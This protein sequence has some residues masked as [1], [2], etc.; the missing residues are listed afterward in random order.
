MKICVIY[1]NQRK[2]STYNCVQLFKTALQKHTQTEFIEFVLPKDMPHICLGCF[3]C[4]IKGED[5]C[6]HAASVQPIA[7]ALLE[8]DGIIISSPTYACDAASSVKALFDHLCY[9]WVPHRP[10]KEMFNKVVM[11]ISVTAGAGVHTSV[12]TLKKSPRYWCV[13][14]VYGFGM[15]VT[16]AFW[17]DVSEKKKKKL[18]AGLEKKAIQFSSS[19]KK[20]SKPGARLQTRI[21]VPLIRNMVKKYKPEDVLFRDKQYWQANG[22]LDGKKP[23]NI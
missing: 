8:S 4:L 12:K 2:E 19:L 14:K 23:W 22:W 3:N 13:R 9:M 15:P 6:P 5:K 1:G 20:A 11:A 10:Q 18:E 7:K 21:M 17:K 16:A